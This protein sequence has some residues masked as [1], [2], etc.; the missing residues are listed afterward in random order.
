[1]IS[2]FNQSEKLWAE[3]VEEFV[4]CTKQNQFQ[5]KLGVKLGTNDAH[6]VDCSYQLKIHDVFVVR[7]F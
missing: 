4:R 7:Q 3:H 5:I 1:M 6:F 2:K